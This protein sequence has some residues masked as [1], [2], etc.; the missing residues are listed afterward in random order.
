MHIHNDCANSST[1]PVHSIQN[2]PTDNTFIVRVVMKH[3]QDHKQIQTIAMPYKGPYHYTVN[4]TK[5]KTLGAW[6]SSG[7]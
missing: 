2:M 3:D 5:R 6:F 7:F 1:Q 4:E